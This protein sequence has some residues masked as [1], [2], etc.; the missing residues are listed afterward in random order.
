MVKFHFFRTR[1]LATELSSADPS[2]KTG[3]LYLLA[4]ELLLVALLYFPIGGA[5]QL[6]ILYYLQGL[7]VLLITFAGI[8]EAYKRN[9]GP[10][11]RAFVVRS[12]CLLFPITLNVTIVSEILR[13]GYFLMVPAIADPSLFTDTMRPLILIEFVWAPAFAAIIFWRLNVHLGRLN[14]TSTA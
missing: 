4:G 3:W 7:I 5:V 11:G 6:Y 2:E 10:H 9:G 1:R 13:Q 8:H 12:I 14:A